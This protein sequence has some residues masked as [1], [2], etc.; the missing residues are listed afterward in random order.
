MSIRPLSDEELKKR[1]DLSLLSIDA[2][3]ELQRLRLKK[4]TSFEN[5]KQLSVLIKED[6]A[7]RLDYSEI[8]K[9]TY[10]STYSS[11][12][13]ASLNRR[14]FY[15]L[16]VSNQLDSPS[17]IKDRE[18]EKLVNFCVNLSDY[19]AIHEEEIRILKEGPCF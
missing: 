11:E 7:N 6:F 5:T 2:A 3:E 17:N 12:I 13:P 8:F 19:S 1:R 9:Q 10:Y 16:R 15:M 4:D 18:L 14:I